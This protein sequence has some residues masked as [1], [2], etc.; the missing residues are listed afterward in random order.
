MIYQQQIKV[1]SNLNSCL[2]LIADN[3]LNRNIKLNEVKSNLRG[4]KFVILDGFCDVLPIKIVKT[5]I[6]IISNLKFKSNH[7]SQDCY[8]N[9]LT[10]VKNSYNQLNLLNLMFI[11][12]VIVDN[13]VIYKFKISVKFDLNSFNLIN[14]PVGVMEYFK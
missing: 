3:E 4:V 9:Y 10:F 8:Y 13:S 6:N 11:D 14:S 12:R 2:N 1:K 7:H 5:Y